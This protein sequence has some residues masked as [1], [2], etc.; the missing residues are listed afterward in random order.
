MDPKLQ[1]AVSEAVL[2][3]RISVHKLEKCV[4]ACGRGGLIAGLVGFVLEGH[5]AVAG[6]RQGA[7]HPAI[8]IARRQPLAREAARL[9]LHISIGEGVPPK[10]GQFGHVLR[11]EQRPRLAGLD[12]RH[13]QIRYPIGQIQM[14]GAARFIAGIV[15]KFEERLDVGMPGFKVDASGAFAFAALIDGSYG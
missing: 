15:A 1:T 2:T 11:V 7:H 13:E 9:G 5:P 8:Q 10:I 6:L 3:S 4:T 14:M 12:A